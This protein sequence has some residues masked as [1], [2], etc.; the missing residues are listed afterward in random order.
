MKKI[1]FIAPHLSTGGLPQY[2]VKKIETLKDNLEVFCIEY[3]NIT[4]GV[5]VIQRKRIENLLDSKHF[6]TL[7]KDKKLELERIVNDIKPDFIHLEEIPEY[8]LSKEEADIIYKKDRNY[9]IFETSHDSSFDPDNKKFYFPDAFL[10]VSNW[11]IEQYKNIDIPKYLAEYPITFKERPD[12][13]QTLIKLGLDPKKRHILN[14]GL[15]TPRKNQAEIFDLAKKFD[16]TVEFHFLGNQADNFKFYW[17]P[18]L[19]NIP[20]NCRI[21]GERND[22]DAF[23]SCMDLFLFTSKGNNGDKET[24]PLVLREAIGWNIPV[25]LY[26]LD[27]YQNYFDKFDNVHYLKDSD[28]NTDLIKSKLNLRVKQKFFDVSY[29]QNEGKISYSI[30][31][32]HPNLS[33][34]NVRMRDPLTNL[35]FQSIYSDL[36]F[37]K[38]GGMWMIPNAK[39]DHRNGIL[40]E[41]FDNNLN[42][43]QSESFLDL[44]KSTWKP[45]VFPTTEIIIENKKIDLKC[46]PIDHSSFWSFYEIFI[47]EDYKNIE[48]N[49]VVVDIG[50]N[51]GLFSLYA[52]TMGAKKIYSV[53]PIR[54][55]FNYLK[56]NTKD[57]DNISVFNFGIGSKNEEVE[58]LT[59][60]VSSIS[61]KIEYTENIEHYWGLNRKTEKVKII[62]ANDFIS[63]NNIE[64]IDYLKIDCEGAELDF[65]KTLN[66]DYLQH[67]IKKITGEIH[68]NSIG[69]DGY[70]YIVNLLKECGFEYNDNYEKGRELSNFYC[71]KKPKIK[72]VHL[73]NNVDGDREKISIESLKKLASYGLYYEQLITPKF[74]DLPPTENCQR[75]YAISK[76]PGDY[77]LAPSHYGCYLSHKKA[78][79]DDYIKDYDAILICECDCTV[80]GE[81]KEVYE[82]IINTY[83]L[84]NKHDL[85]S[86]SFGKQI[87]GVE[88]I[89]VEEDLFYTSKQ[90]EA[91]C[92]LITKSHIKE[93][94]DKLIYTKWDAYDLWSNIFFTE[95]KRGIYKIPYALQQPGISSID[96]RFKEGMDIDPSTPIFRLEEIDTDISVIIQSCDN[97][98]RFWNGWY[99]SFSRYWNWELNW[100]VYFCTEEKD[101]PFNDFRINNIKSPKSI[102][103]TQFSNRLLD[104]LNKVQTKYVLYMQEDMWLMLHAD[105]ETFKKALYKLRVNDWNCLRIH[106]KLWGTYEFLKT[107]QFIKGNRILK[108]KNNSEWLLT[109]NACIWN[110][111]FLISCIEENEN[112]WQNEIQGTVRIA[113]KYLDTKIYHLNKRWYYQ[114]GAS[115]GGNLNPFMEEYERYLMYS[116]DLKDEFDI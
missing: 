80:F 37:K 14:V 25:L 39:Q 88:H 15:F 18:L 77:L 9:K 89:N 99:L 116:R 82:K 59:G 26:N 115:Q 1:I 103:S 49:D 63:E 31:A 93:Y 42:V 19:K 45:N 2:L 90:S 24:M 108:A 64:Y 65:F 58:F 21:W 92:Y 51:I 29:D 40:V 50:S 32:D 30:I 41:F 16:N 36:P 52:A 83:F 34:Y 62:N 23:Y 71:H 46:N 100:P 68:I 85:I 13:D 74:I 102:D 43:I 4:G 114:P 48:H 97:Y 22:T 78:I 95:R 112:P 87:P 94:A 44:K 66:K 53:E 72:I 7:G 91:H 35:V 96:M 11:Q 28:F 12:R 104:I 109:H 10:F 56:H 6:I 84:N 106:E 70:L 105:Y 47:R 17:E 107:N 27:V 38:G 110:R 111:E 86:T 8:F 3:E 75:P 73:L 5:L 57:L 76:E 20:S 54:E 79:C 98:E 69:V 67:K 101:L 60:E 55:T 33:S 61:G 81:Y 113:N